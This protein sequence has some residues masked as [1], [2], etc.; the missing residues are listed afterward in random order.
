MEDIIQQLRNDHQEF[1]KGSLEGYFGETPFDLLEKWYT[2]AV[3]RKQI[4]A[5][6]FVLST[7]NE[8]LQVSSRVLYLK[9]ITDQQFIFYT[10][11]LSRKGGDLAHNPAASMLFFWPG[12]QRQLRIEGRVQ[13]IEEPIS[14]A[15]FASRPR[16]SQL[17]AWASHQS[18][19]LDKRTTLEQRIEQYSQQFKDTVP[20]PPHWGG[21]ALTPHLIEF[22]QGRP[23]R[24]H[25]RIVYEK[26]ETAWNV[27]R[28]N[29]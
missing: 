14:D 12:L 6:A 20:R 3:Q 4:E 17:G 24:L 15:Y 28:K 7:V 8:Q 21:Y 22:W 19:L 13:K 2:E 23:S 27:Y 10:N 18:E 29:P 5:N 1:D 16:G 9:E 26:K 25:D 11:Y